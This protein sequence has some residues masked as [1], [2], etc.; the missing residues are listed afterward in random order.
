MKPAEAPAE[1]L[2]RFCCKMLLFKGAPGSGSTLR[3]GLPIVQ[4]RHLDVFSESLD[5]IAGILEA[6]LCGDFFYGKGSAAQKM[7]CVVDPALHQILHRRKAAILLKTAAGLAAA[8][9]GG[10]C[11]RLEGDFFGEVPVDIR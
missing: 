4:R 1:A 11:D 10:G 6:A 2:C 3:P 7:L 8:D 5:E 9:I